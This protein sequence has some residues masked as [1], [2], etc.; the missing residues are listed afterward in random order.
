M[1]TRYRGVDEARLQ[2]S[3][4][5]LATGPTC[6]HSPSLE[7]RLAMAAH[8]AGATFVHHES[9]AFHGSVFVREDPQNTF[10]LSAHGEAFKR[11]Y[12]FSAQYARR[13][14]PFTPIAFMVAFDQGWRPRER[15][16]G[17]WAPDR[18]AASLEQMFRHVYNWQ[19]RLDFERG[20]LSSGP[21]GDVFDVLTGDA[22][23]ETIKNYGVL[24]PLG[25]I[26]PTP[27]QR[28]ELEDY[29]T[30]G[31]VLVLDSAH[32]VDF[33]HRFLGMSVASRPL[34]A[35]GIQTALQSIPTITTPFPYR[36][37]KPGDDAHALAWTESGAPLLAWRGVGKGIVIVSATDHWLDADSELVP[38]AGALLRTLADAFVPVHTTADVEVLINR[39]IHGFVIGLV[40][41]HGVSKV[42]TEAALIDSRG[43]RECVITFDTGAPQRFI[44][45]MGEFRW[46]APA[47][48]LL[49][50]IP[51]GDVAVVE[52]VTEGP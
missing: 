6:G 14:I 32:A 37:L 13:G 19:G 47:N 17:I 38:I 26:T 3:P 41:N 48:G 31:G 11:W 34:H 27:R 4:P 49:T 51:P 8:L 40:N 35:T 39:T 23:L 21:Y 28:R 42:P 24:W 15:I 16:F 50:R 18:G 5:D 9:D 33:S 46:S 44:S 2:W 22:V 29:V 30:N 7:F 10:A 25:D 45:R 43:T 52:V 1:D 36:P 20:Y 12:D